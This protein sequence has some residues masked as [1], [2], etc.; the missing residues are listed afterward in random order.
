MEGR[1]PPQEIKEG[2]R[3]A[4][5]RIHVERAIGR[6][7]TYL[8][9]KGTIPLSMARLCNKIVCVCAFLSH[10]QPGHKTN[11]R[12]MWMSTLKILPIQKM[13]T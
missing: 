12:L 6:I 11:L 2:R 5:L 9:C 4:S 7:K 3:I 8:I 1:Q 10:F 13:I